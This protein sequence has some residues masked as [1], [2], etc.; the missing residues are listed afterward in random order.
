MPGMGYVAANSSTLARSWASF[1]SMSGN[2]KVD[3]KV[4]RGDAFPVWEDS[5]STSLAIWMA[6]WIKSPITSISDAVI[7][8]D[9]TAGV[10]MR[11]PLGFN[12]LLSPGTVFLL[13]TKEKDKRDERAENT[14]NL[15]KV[16]PKDVILANI[17]GK[18]F[19]KIGR[20]FFPNL[21]FYCRFLL[22]RRWRF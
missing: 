8:L 22:N 14:T 16:L 11:R 1:K 2:V 20:V 17:R 7:F 12:A 9:V 15:H 19:S 6:R 4:L 18:P 5:S 3:L 13:T 21:L 10:P